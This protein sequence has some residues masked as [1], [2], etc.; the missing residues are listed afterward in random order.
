MKNIFVSFAIEEKF[1]RENLVFQAKQHQTPF[2]F[3]DMSVQTP[4][5][6]SWKTNCRNRIKQCDGLI[7]FLSDNTNKAEGALWETNCAYEEDIP[8]LLVYIHDNGVKAIPRDLSGKRIVHWT[9]PNISNFISS[10]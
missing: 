7:A 4:W 1:E 2:N 6:Y 10:L 8:V 9:W 5:D 3:V